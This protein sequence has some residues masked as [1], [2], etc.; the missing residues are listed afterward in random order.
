MFKKGLVPSIVLLWFLSFAVHAQECAF[1]LTVVFRD[2]IDSTTIPGAE[3]FLVERRQQAITNSDG[4]VQ[5]RLL[6]SGSYLLVVHEESHGDSNYVIEIHA[7]TTLYVF[8]PEHS[9]HLHEVTVIGMRHRETDPGQAFQVIDSD[10]IQQNA[11]SS[12]GEIL[13]KA[14]SNIRSERNGPAI[15]RPQIN[16]FSGNRIAIITNGLRKEAQ[17]WGNEHPPEEDPMAMERIT[18]ITS[19]AAVQYGPEAQGGAILNEPIG[20]TMSPGISGSV[21]S[22]L[23]TVNRGGGLA[24]EIQAVHPALPNLGL[25]LQGNLKGGGNYKTP[26]Y[27]LDNT[28]TRDYHFMGRSQYRHK[29]SLT[30]VYY[31]NYNSTYGV[32]SGAHIG[33]LTDLEAAIGREKP[34]SPDTFMY[35]IASPFQTFRHEVLQL[36]HKQRIGLH[37]NVE[38]N[39]GRQF[40][41]RQEWSRGRDGEDRLYQEYNLRTLSAR[42][43]W[44]IQNHKGFLM[45]A[46]AEVQGKEQTIKGAD[47]L[48]NYYQNQ[49]G[50]FALHKWHKKMWHW[51]YGARLEWRELQ[52]F[53][54]RSGVLEQPYRKYIVPAFF[55]ALM[56]ETAKQEWKL[57]ATYSKR[58][59]GIHELFSN[60]LHHGTAALE[61]G[62]VDVKPEYNAN[63]SLS[64]KRKGLVQDF[65]AEA[66]VYYMPG[67]INLMPQSE[68]ALTIRGAFP[69]FRYLQ[70][71]ALIYGLSLTH[72]LRVNKGLEIRNQGG[73]TLGYDITEEEALFGMPAFRFKSDWSLLKGLKIGQQQHL[74]PFLGIVATATKKQVPA[75][76]DYMPPPKG[77]GLLNAGLRLERQKESAILWNITLRADNILNTAYRD[78]LDRLRYY[79]DAPGR[80]ISL[81]FIY[82]F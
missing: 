67:F 15:Y 53:Y 29:R 43:V 62:N 36:R 9:E 2:Q 7:D 74:F 32:F 31:Q 78:Y 45:Q 11:L 47:F 58:P 82:F 42:G 38:F 44:S 20:L 5:F 81:L 64:G 41:F 68:Y 75:E 19:S 12:Y 57:S 52:A 16:G 59:P 4:Q 21:R 37:Q 72:A 35:A 73:W 65:G 51:E 23:Q 79:A 17:Q 40:N 34:L 14:G 8:V 10:A 70:T 48:P 63:L 56:H 71:D 6:C 61:Y 55:G 49:V 3:V 27:F 39:F 25:Q 1:S 76:G 50:I 33:N 18:L 60:G 80:N 24:A 30:E 77:Y 54:Y 28:G 66:Y 46:G 13:D 26:G 69:V 22:S